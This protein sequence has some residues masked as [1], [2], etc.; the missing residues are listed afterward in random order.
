[1]KLRLKT[2]TP[3]RRKTVEFIEKTA[4]EVRG[5]EKWKLGDY[6]DMEQEKITLVLNINVQV[7]QKYSRT[8]N[9]LTEKTTKHDS[10]D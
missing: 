6:S 7:V 4:K 3:E 9:D 1:M 5:W 2:D 8:W 10:F